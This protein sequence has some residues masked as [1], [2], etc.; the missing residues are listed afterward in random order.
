MTVFEG[1]GYD[2]YISTESAIYGYDFK[3]DKITK[4]LDYVDS[5]LSATYSISAAAAISDTEFLAVLPDFAYNYSLERLVKVPAD[6]VKDKQ[7][8]TLGGSF[9]D[10]TVRQAAV[11][12]N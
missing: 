12:F 9:I 5:D 3:A 8:I 1:N 6:Q 7:V 4:L 10:Y 11:K 2:L